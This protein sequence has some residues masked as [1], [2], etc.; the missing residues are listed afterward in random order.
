MR[1]N[2]DQDH[3]CRKHILGLLAEPFDFHLEASECGVGVRSN[4]QLAFFLGHYCC[5]SGNLRVVASS[6]SKV[7][8][9]TRTLYFDLI[10]LST[11]LQRA[12]LTVFRHT[13]ESF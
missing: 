12:L 7:W 10:L 5:N 3:P 4:P 11:H 8:L 9:E 6:Y 13:P 2:H 1:G